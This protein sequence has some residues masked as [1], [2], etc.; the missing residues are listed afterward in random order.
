MIGLCKQKSVSVVLS[1]NLKRNYTI[2]CLYYSAHRDNMDSIHDAA[3]QI[4]TP[5]IVFINNILV[6]LSDLILVGDQTHVTLA[7]TAQPV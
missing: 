6:A 3:K 2:V 7:S 1:F 5:T 4:I